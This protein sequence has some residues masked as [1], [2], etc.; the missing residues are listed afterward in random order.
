MILKNNE[1]SNGMPDVS[2][3]IEEYMLVKKYKIFIAFDDMIADN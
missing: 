1:Y 3:N 2:K